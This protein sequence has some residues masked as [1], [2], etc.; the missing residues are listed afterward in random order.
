MGLF[1]A[2]EPGLGRTLH[3][4]RCGVKLYLLKDGVSLPDLKGNYVFQTLEKCEKCGRIYCNRCQKGSCICGSY[5]L[6]GS[7]KAVKKIDE[8][9][10]ERMN[11]F[12]K[13]Q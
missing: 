2:K 13:R 11:S 4:S 5:S 10:Q 6:R 8:Q 7:I 1:N 12:M 3:C 9:M